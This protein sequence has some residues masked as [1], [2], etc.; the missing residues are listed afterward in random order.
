MIP[1]IEIAES[2]VKI[3]RL[4]CGT[5]AFCGISHFTKS[6]DMFL[7]EYFRDVS[8][9]AE[10]MEYLFEEFGVNVC[11]SSPRDSI[12]KAIEMVE[13]EM[14]EKYHWLCT[15]SGT[16]QTAKGTGSK[17]KEQ[18]KW[19]ADHNVTACMP[20]RSWT[21]FRLNKDRNEITDVTEHL[22]LIRDL[23]MS[24]GLSTHYY[25]TLRIC[26]QKKYDVDLVIQPVNPIGFQSNIEVNTLLSTIQN[27]KIQI[28]AIKP[29]AAGRLVPEIGLNFAFQNIKPNDF[30]ACGFD[31][32]QNADYDAQLAEKI[33]SK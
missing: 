17:L 23:G 33:L 26:H 8:K 4:I 18:I 22:E 5:N 2:G 16:R 9:I 7:E 6:Q 12:A 1:K 15:P 13:N 21:D 25:E 14:G 31:C 28:I 3:S 27:T 11:I 30:V 29:L 24:T 19:C 32:I 20:H 10:I